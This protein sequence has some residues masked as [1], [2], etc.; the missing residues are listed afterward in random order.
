MYSTIVFCLFSWNEIQEPSSGSSSDP[1]GRDFVVLCLHLLSELG[2]LRQHCRDNVT[3]LSGQTI[4]AFCMN[5]FS[6][7]ATLFRHRGLKLFRIFV[8]HLLSR[9]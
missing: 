8:G 3:M 9:S 2:T 1:L 7:V 4:V 5:A 6:V